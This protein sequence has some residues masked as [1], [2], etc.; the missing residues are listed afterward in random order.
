VDVAAVMYATQRPQ[1]VAVETENATGPVGKTKASWYLVCDH[2]NAIPP[3]VQRFMAQPTGATTDDRMVR[4]FLAGPP[5]E[6]ADEPPVPRAAPG[7]PA[8][9]AIPAHRRAA[10]SSDA[11][12]GLHLGVARVLVR[13]PVAMGHLVT[14]QAHRQPSGPTAADVPIGPEPV[15]ELS[16]R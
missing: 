8:D 13:D 5:G 2:D 10:R 4:P 11:S 15:H 12:I 1:S 14:R 3:D 7:R 16:G 6:P 9:P